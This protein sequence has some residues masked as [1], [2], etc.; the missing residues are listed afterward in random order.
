MQEE[1]ENL[2]SPISYKENEFIIDIFHK[3][4]SRLR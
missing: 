2:D 1:M 3:E 4:N